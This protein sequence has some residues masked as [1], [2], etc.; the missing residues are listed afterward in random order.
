[1]KYVLGADVGGTTVKLGL[2]SAEGSL[3]EKWE[4]PTRTENGGAEILPDIAASLREAL[5]RHEIAA[6][7]VTG[8]GIAVPG[9]VD[10]NGTVHGCVNLGWGVLDI[11]SEMN[12]LLPEIPHVAAG[13]DANAATLGELWRGGGAG[14]SSTAMFTLG[15]GVGGGIVVNGQMV[16]GAGGGAG[17]LGH[18]TVEPGE[19][20][21]CA[22]GKCGCLEQ[23]ASANGIVRMGR[24]MLEQ[25]DTPSALRSME[26]FTARDICDLARDGEPMACSIVDRFGEYLG[27]AL[28][29]VAATVD[30]DIF[31]IGGGMS[32]A[33]SVIIDAIAG[34]YRRYAFHISVDTP[35]VL[36][37]LG[38]D[39]GIYGCA[40]MASSDAAPKKEL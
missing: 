11:K 14:H 13:N 2:F 27:R 31:I 17:E 40:K 4:I 20:V 34:Y 24:V 23:Y 32:R 16:A 7:D 1:M 28:S 22:C 6:G 38:N 8:I 26:A 21:P 9:P 18:I 29:F 3:L 10:K 15:T 19:T 25:C 33:G 39:A 5:A 35:I 12:R 36:A 37:E 30:P